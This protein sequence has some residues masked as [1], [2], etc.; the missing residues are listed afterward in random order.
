MGEGAELLQR[1]VAGQAFATPWAAAG[2]CG[3]GPSSSRGGTGTDQARLAATVRTLFD[4]SPP[5][6]AIAS[7]AL[8]TVAQS[9][10]AEDDDVGTK[11]EQLKEH[12]DSVQREVEADAHSRRASEEASIEAIKER[13]RTLETSLKAETSK[14][15]ERR[16]SLQAAFE[17][18]LA[19]AQRR[20]EAE[21]LER[22]DQVRSAL[23]DLEDRTQS[24]ETDFGPCRERFL[25]QLRG[26]NQEL[27]EQLKEVEQELLT[28]AR[29]CRDR[30]GYLLQRIDESGKRAADRLE[31]QRCLWELKFGELLEDAEA[32]ARAREGAQRR[33]REDMVQKIAELRRILKDAG[34]A[35][36][37]ADDQITVA[38]NHYTN[39]LQ[40][41]LSEASQGMVEATC[42]AYSN[43]GLKG[44]KF[45]QHC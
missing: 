21:F 16:R 5:P 26:R 22:F 43:N 19:A 32:C 35:R 30:E 41:A 40:E 4:T 31:R 36:Q 17:S 1:K 6:S 9:S 24:V 13:V 44:P 25:G 28:E 38:L 14:E 39:A 12:F 23:D 37:A 8:P 20:V 3:D 27:G 10:P 29:G 34:S 15:E 42:R 33:L 7:A 18:R 2:V 11:L 45:N